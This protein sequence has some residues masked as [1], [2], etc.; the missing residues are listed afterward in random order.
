MTT[1]NSYRDYLRS[2]W[3]EYHSDHE[4]FYEA[5][6]DELVFR[7]CFRR[8]YGRMPVTKNYSHVR[9]VHGLG[10]YSEPGLSW[11]EYLKSFNLD[12]R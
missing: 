12:V 11:S 10:T 5:R 4:A 9:F 1:G 2:I 6:S 8:L 3:N 7:H